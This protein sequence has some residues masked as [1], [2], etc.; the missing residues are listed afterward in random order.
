MDVFW[1]NS[2]VYRD[3]NE[4]ILMWIA[5]FGLKDVNNWIGVGLQT[6]KIGIIVFG[7]WWLLRNMQDSGLRYQHYRYIL[8]I[9][10]GL[11]GTGAKAYW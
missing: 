1:N 8:S 11:A 5:D 2:C 10:L 9:S 7:W 3:I 4:R 6:Y